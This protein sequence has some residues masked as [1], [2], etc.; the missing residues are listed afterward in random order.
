MFYIYLLYPYLYI[1]HCSP[2]ILFGN[3]D[4]NFIKNLDVLFVMIIS[5][6]CMSFKLDNIYKALR[7]VL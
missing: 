4:G 2:Q 5:I 3:C 7:P 6:G 1:F